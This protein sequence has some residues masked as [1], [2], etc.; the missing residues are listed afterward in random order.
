MK[1][2]YAEK[3]ERRYMNGRTFAATVLTPCFMREHRETEEQ[4]LRERALLEV[5]KELEN[6]KKY[7]IEI[8]ADTAERYEVGAIETRVK[9]QVEEMEIVPVVIDIDWSRYA[10]QPKKRRRGWR[11]SS[12]KRR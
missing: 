10:P 9:I 1:K 4:Y 3:G 12:W 5:A 8:T 6:G 11:R 2:E 7:V